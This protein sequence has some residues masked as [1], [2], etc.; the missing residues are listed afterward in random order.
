MTTNPSIDLNKAKKV[1]E[2]I[3][4]RYKPPKTYRLGF[5]LTY[6]EIV[7]KRNYNL[8]EKLL[9]TIKN[10]QQEYAKKNSKQGKKD[11]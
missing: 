7:G 11:C 10:I 4:L 6:G 2:E 8:T 3:K 1:L 9:Q 5:R